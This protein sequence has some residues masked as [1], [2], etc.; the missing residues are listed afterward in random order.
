MLDVRISSIEAIYLLSSP[1]IMQFTF[2]G[3]K[4][5]AIHVFEKCVF[6]CVCVSLK[7]DAKLF[8]ESISEKNEIGHYEEHT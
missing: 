7:D 4:I 1:C 5:K 3:I 2:Q 6:V 8:E